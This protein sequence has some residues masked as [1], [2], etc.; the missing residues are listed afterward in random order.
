VKLLMRA[1]VVTGEVLSS[2]S[3]LRAPFWFAILLYA[4][5]WLVRNKCCSS[6]SVD[7][8]ELYLFLPSHVIF[9]PYL[10]VWKMFIP[11]YPDYVQLLQALK[12]ISL[13][14]LEA[15]TAPWHFLETRYKHLR[16]SPGSPVLLLIY[17]LQI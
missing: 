5:C 12:L 14:T 6:E 8:R 10:P 13:H 4:C 11:A 9:K 3:C 16:I 1:K 7:S 17:V 2:S 15:L